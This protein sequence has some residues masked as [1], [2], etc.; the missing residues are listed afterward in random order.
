M[1]KAF[2][3]CLFFLLISFGAKAQMEE[4]RVGWKENALTWSDFKGA[5]DPASPFS[6]NTSS[7]ISYG[8]S[9]KGSATGKEYSSEVTSFFIP[10]KSWV[11]GG[12]ASAKLLDHEQLHFDITELFAR[13]L[14]KALAEFD[15]DNAPDLKADLQ[16]LYNNAERERALVQQKFDVETRHSM[17]EAAQLEWQKFI[18]KELKK[19][20]DFSS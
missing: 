9:M 19:L 3:S 6:A 2:F 8:W 12:S 18:K 13:K 14:R 7:G 10:G 17:N 4:E 1:K 11:K 20:E 16:A 5:P 15:F